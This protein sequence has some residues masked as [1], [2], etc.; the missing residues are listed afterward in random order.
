VI[1]APP[2]RAA[3][4]VETELKLAIAPADVPRLARSAVLRDATRSS[5]VTRATHSVYYDTPDHALRRGGMALRLRREG[6]RWLQT[7]KTAG[8]VDAGLHAR[9]E[10]EVVRAR[11]QIDFATLADTPLGPA[12]DDAGFRAALAPVFETTFRRTARLVALSADSTAELVLDRGEVIA[13]DTRT[14]LCEVEIELR[15]GHAADLFA[16]AARLARDVPLRLAS[17]SKAARGYALLDADPAPDGPVKAAPLVLVPAAAVSDTFATLLRHGI[18]HLHANEDGLV[19]ASADIEYV[20]QARVALRRLRSA[21]RL[22]RDVVPRDTVAPVT[23]RLRLLAQHLGE[24]RDWDVFLAETL[25]AVEAAIPGDETLAGLHAQA[26]SLRRTARDATA[27]TAADADWTVLL[28]DLSGLAATQPW[29]DALDAE[30][31]A[32]A[33]LPVREYAASLLARQ[34]KRVRRHGRD[35]AGLDPSALHALRIEIKKLRYATEFFQSL[36]PRKAVRTWI[37]ATTALQS[38]LGTLNDAAVTQRLLGRLDGGD[39]DSARAC[40]LVRGFTAARADAVLAQLAPAWARF[41]SARP[42]W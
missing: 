39:A 41:R 32:R 5:P 21:F 38:L 19:E 6:R 34:A 18:A 13:G 15:T 7:L 14:P 42:F 20:H 29:R 3:V 23:D 33:A 31:Q 22:F 26:A 10:H 4:A 2:G 27:S 12:L 9:E 17:V 36:F 16:F 40:G 11:A 25:A 35:V 1:D 8:R 37:D 24:T 28:L 30:A